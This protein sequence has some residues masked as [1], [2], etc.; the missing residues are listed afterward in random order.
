ME[1]IDIEKALIPYRFD[2][3]IQNEIFTM[4]VHY[5]PDYDFFAIDLE[6]NGEALVTGEKLVYGQPLFRDVADHR[7]PGLPLVPYDESGQ[8]Q[9]VNAET[10]SESVFLFIMDANGGDGD[11]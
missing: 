4:E 1:Y 3:S 11:A 6:K 7:F 9:E 8:R 10:L 5:N 2:V